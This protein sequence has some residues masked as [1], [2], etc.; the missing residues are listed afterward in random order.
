MTREEWADSVREA[1]AI[2]HDRL[3]SPRFT[4]AGEI[5]EARGRRIVSLI[6]SIGIEEQSVGPHGPRTNI[7]WLTCR[8]GLDTWDSAGP[9]RIDGP[10]DWALLSALILRAGVYGAR[11]A[12]AREKAAAMGE[13]GALMTEEDGA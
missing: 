10:D 3:P 1:I 8:H 5:I 7:V 2:L 13:R 11:S 4:I 12:Y 9:L 6:A